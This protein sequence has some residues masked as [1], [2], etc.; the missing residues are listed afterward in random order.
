MIAQNTPGELTMSS[1]N[2]HNRYSMPATRSRNGLYDSGLDQTNTTRF[3]FGDD[4]P[5]A[6]ARGATPDNNFPTLVR[7]NDQIVSKLIH[8]MFYCYAIV[9]YPNHLSSPAPP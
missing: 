9:L 5:S 7:H 1:E 8:N 3:L 4:E 2:S 6:F